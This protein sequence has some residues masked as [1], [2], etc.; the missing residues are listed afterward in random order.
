MSG[1]RE[2][3]M[4]QR[5]KIMAAPK[6][7]ASPEVN[8]RNLRGQKQTEREDLIDEGVREARERKEN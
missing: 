6:T 5:R 3:P 1:E 4:H 2:V 7:A 8:P